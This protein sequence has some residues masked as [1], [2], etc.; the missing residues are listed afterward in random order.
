MTN[1]DFFNQ[2]R[3]LETNRVIAVLVVD[4]V[5]AAVP[6]AQALIAGGIKTMELTLRTPNAVEC[7]ARVK[8][9]LPDMICGAGTVVSAAQVKRVK[10]A[11][12]DFAVA[13]GLNP[14]VLEAAEAESLPFGPGVATPS[15]IEIATSRGYTTLKFFPAEP[16]G[17]LSY[18]K[19]MAGPYKHLGVRFI[20]L[21]G[22]R[23]SSIADYLAEGLIHA[24]GGS[25]LAKPDVIQAHD[26][27]TVRANSEEA[28]KLAEHALAA[29][30]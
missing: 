11:G 5:A 10:Q 22:L 2:N 17:G 6:L 18:L 7:L 16:L 29:R 15:D 9:D 4:D 30:G 14:A 12:A 8:Q 24:I 3:F 1:T 26:W 13:P 25:W 28:S 23:S 19:A 21:G 20:P 27:D